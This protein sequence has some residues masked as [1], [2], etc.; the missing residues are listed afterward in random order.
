MKQPSTTTLLLA[1][2]SLF[3]TSARAAEP[4]AELAQTQHDIATYEAKLKTAPNDTEAS[5]QLAMNLSKLG[6]LLY[7]REQLGDLDQAVAHH[8]RALEIR[9]KLLAADPTST[10]ASKEV[11]VSL[12]RFADILAKRA[13]PG[14]DDNAVAYYNRS[15]SIREK[16]LAAAPESVEA[17]QDVSVAHYKIATYAWQHKDD[18]SNREHCRANYDMLKPR[19]EKGMIFDGPTMNFYKQL[20][21]R[22]SGK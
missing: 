9:E 11:S 10:I 6:T 14:D 15:L 4:E 1:I 19:I 13:K 7:K 8:T 21:K 16:L 12:G 3:L 5:R 22:F 20:D 2:T 18:K 17:A